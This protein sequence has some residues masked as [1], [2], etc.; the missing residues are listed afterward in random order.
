MPRG[1]RERQRHAKHGHFAGMHPRLGEHVDVVGHGLQAGIRSSA[2]RIRE[3]EERRDTGPAELPGEIGGEAADLGHQRGQ[4][5]RLGEHAVDDQESVGQHEPEKYRQ[6]D[7]DH[8]LYPAQVEHHEHHD[9]HHLGRELVGLPVERQQREKRVDAARDGDGDGEHVVDDE[10]RAG[11]QARVGT[12][13][14]RGDAVAAAS[15][16]EELDDLVVGKRDDE[17][18]RRGGEREV[19]PHL[20]VLAQRAERLLRPVAR[21]GDSVSAQPHPG[22]ESGEGDM[23]PGLGVQGIERSAEEPAAQVQKGA[24]EAARPRDAM[25]FSRRR[26]NTVISFAACL[27]PFFSATSI[28]LR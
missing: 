26:A 17:H 24:H 4:H 28:P 20:R 12:D 6:Q 15:G 8:L 9:Q 3:Q 5:R 16:R 13:Q 22:E 21:G 19:Q 14:P 7:G 23:P 25:L 11:G 1:K 2:L 10:R 18:G 27:S